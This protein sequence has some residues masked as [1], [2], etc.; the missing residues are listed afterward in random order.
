MRVEE[1]GLELVLLTTGK[2]EDGAGSRMGT[3]QSIP[4]GVTV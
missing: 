2:L 3:L 1:T 4:F